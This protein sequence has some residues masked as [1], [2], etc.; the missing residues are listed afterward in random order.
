MTSG[1]TIL[2]ALYRRGTLALV[3]AALLI[4]M[5][6]PSHAEEVR[7]LYVTQGLLCAASNEG[8]PHREAH[9]VLCLLPDASAAPESEIAE[10]RLVVEAVTHTVRQPVS[11]KANV[12]SRRARAPPAPFV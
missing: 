6:R 3:L 10:R 1:A 5:P 12:L 11:K 9:C 2:K 7:A 8:Q 4:P